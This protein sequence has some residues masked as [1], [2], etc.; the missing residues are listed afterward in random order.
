[1]SKLGIGFIGC[2][3]IHNAHAPHLVDNDEAYIACAM[4]VNA[5]AAKAHCEKYGTKK[6]TTSVDELL[7][8]PE[9]D[10]VIICTPTGLHKDLVLKA[11]AAG[12]N[13]FC[14]KP[15]AMNVADCEI[16]DKAARDAGVVLQIGFVRHF[17]NEW[18]KLRELIQSG[19]IGRPVVWRSVSGGSGAPT[20]W[21]FNK[22]L[23]GGPFID[24]AV[25]SYDWAR[26]IFGEATNVVTDIRKLKADTTAWDTG[27]VIV[28][29][30]SGDQQLIIWSWGLPGFGGKVKADSAH[31]VLGPLGSITFPG[32]NKLQ[33]NLEEGEQEVEFE[34]DGG[35]DWFRK[36]M[37]SFIECCKTGKAPIAGAKEGIEATR[38]AAAA[39]SVGNRPA[40]IEL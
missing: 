33:V 15:M 5:D 24:G 32:G 3:G 31:D 30:E 4:D 9:V 17:C 19:I 29:F 13:I 18:L 20:P 27:T 40:I 26:Y 34:A 16:M 1:M 12:K 6:W 37:A 22:E 36:Q 28:N 8:T 2:G 39:L 35:T 23:G 10:A 14:E 7:A 21:F 38:I 11:A 25:H